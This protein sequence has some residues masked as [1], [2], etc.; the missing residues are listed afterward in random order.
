MSAVASAAVGAGTPADL[1]GAALRVAL[2]LALLAPLVYVVTRAYARRLALGGSVRAMRVV[3]AL[4]LGP[5]RAVYLV[6]VGERLLVLGV[7]SQQVTLLAEVT[8]PEAVAALKER[9][10][11]DKSAFFGLFSQRLGVRHGE[12]EGED[13]R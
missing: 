1:W 11:G 10:I 2:A 6:E 5:N 9:G 8:D 3:D 12:P 4:G 7:T 13:G